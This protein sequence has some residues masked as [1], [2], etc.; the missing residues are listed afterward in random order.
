MRIAAPALFAALALAACYR[1]DYTSSEP[2]REIRLLHILRWDRDYCW[3]SYDTARC[4]PAIL[5]QDDLALLRREPTS[6]VEIRKKA[7]LL[8]ENVHAMNDFAWQWWPFRGRAWQWMGEREGF[9]VQIRYLIR[10]GV[11]VDEDHYVKVLTGPPYQ[12]LCSEAEA[13]AFIRWAIER[14]RAQPAGGD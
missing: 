5:E 2:P 12:R 13:R 3:T 14:A 10:H 11:E 4:P 7:L 6:D 1:P 9:E 8:H